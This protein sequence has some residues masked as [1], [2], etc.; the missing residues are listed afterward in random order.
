[1]SASP[2]AAE[3][4][5]AA[6]KWIAPAVVAFVLLFVYHAT[7]A[8]TVTYWDAGEFLSAIHSLGIPHPPG[9]PL[10]VVIANV[11]TKIFSPWLGFAIQ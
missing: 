5:S 9:T 7:L 8:P 4:R 10:F 3:N 11:W 1:L 2:A 6:Q